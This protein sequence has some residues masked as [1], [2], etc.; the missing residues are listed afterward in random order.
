MSSSRVDVMLAG[1]LFYD[2]VM[3]GLGGEPE[4]GTEVHARELNRGPGGI[5]TFAVALA[6]L[7]CSTRLIASCG[8]DLFGQLC[9]QA[10]A[11]EGID[12]T[13][14]P[15][16]PGWPT[17]LTVSLSYDGDRS[18]VTHD[19]I[20]APE[21]VWPAGV[22][23][24]ASIVHLTESSGPWVRQAREHGG[25]VFADV[26]WDPTGTWDNRLLTQLE[27]CHA[28][29][30]NADE[31]MAYTGT[32]SPK[33]AVRKL[34]ERVPLAVVTRGSAGVIAIDGS[35]GETA[36]V[37]AVPVVQ[38]DPT[39]AGDVFGAALVAG[40]LSGWPLDQRIGVASLC[41]AL[42]V[43]RVGSATAAPDWDRLLRWWQ[44]VRTGSDQALR[45]RYGFLDDLLGTI[46][47]T[48]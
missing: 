42:A 35:T 30:P 5:A 9:H 3:S 34:A 6:R 12:L 17:P 41:A 46:T 40:T 1:L 45:W 25:L 8:D 32:H 26:G 48:R 31:A 28:F 44:G 38:A 13:D 19:P 15:L 47:L 16:R 10:L 43:E 21:P 4:L 29:L 18:L 22:S 33:Q 24:R 27:S 20:P 37:P 36:E 23:S 7:G 2:L 14:V 11:D 39:G